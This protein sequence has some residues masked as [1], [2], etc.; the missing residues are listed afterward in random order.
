MDRKTKTQK[1]SKSTYET[2]DKFCQDQMQTWKNLAE[3]QLEFAQLW[4]DYCGACFQR[5]SAAKDVSELYAIEA[6]LA[7]EYGSRFANCSRKV[8]EAVSDSQQEV[9]EY[10][11]SPESLFRPMFMGYPALWK[12]FTEAAKGSVEEDK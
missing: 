11:T 3:L 2:V 12:N 10:L 8:F 9:M 4:Q 7:A 5:L 1:D 6:G